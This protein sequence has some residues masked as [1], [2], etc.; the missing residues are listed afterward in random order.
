MWDL[1]RR[2]F[3]FCTYCLLYKHDLKHFGFRVSVGP[4][5]FI[6]P[7]FGPA[8]HSLIP[9]VPGPVTPGIKRQGVKLTSRLQLVPSSRKR[10]ST[11]PLPHM[12]L[13]HSAELVKESDRCRSRKLILTTV[14]DPP[15]WPRDTPLSTKVGTKFR[16]QV[17]VA[18]SV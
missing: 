10:D 14:G 12:P 7:S 15:P 4:R 3:Y 9:G 11:H 5:M 13:W 16:R 8:L 18:Q 2:W 6:Y 17:A 1:L